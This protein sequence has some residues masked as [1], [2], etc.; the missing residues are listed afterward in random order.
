MEK[1]LNC[2]FEFLWETCVTALDD[3]VPQDQ[4][5]SVQ[6]SNYYTIGRYLKE[7]S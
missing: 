3:F 6:A 1:S 5:E 2:V 4:S 7:V